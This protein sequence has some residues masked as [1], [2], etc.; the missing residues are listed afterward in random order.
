VT[1]AE[2]P[3]SP[4]TI[5][6]P[7][8]IRR[9]TILLALSQAFTGAGMGMF[10]AIGPLM[11]TGISGSTVLAGLSVTLAGLAR[12]L[13]AY[14]IGRVTDTHGRKPAMLGGLACA[15]LGTLLVGVAMLVASL[16]LLLVALLVFAMAMNAAYQLRVAATDMYPPSRR[17]EGL[18]FVLTG[19]LLGV[20]VG[21]VLI[22]IS[23]SIAPSLGV[24][25][26]G[27]PWL[28]F[29]IV[30][31]PGMYCIS[32][33][34]P[35][36]KEIAQCLGDFYPGF[37]PT[38]R[39]VQRPARSVTLRNFL[40]HYPRR[41][42]VFTNVAAQGNM[43]VVM[44]TSALLLHQ[45][46][47]TLSEISVSAAL[48][49]LGMWIVS[50]PLGRLTDRVGRRAVLMLGGVMSTG[51]AILATQTTEWWSITLGSFLVGVGWSAATVAATVVIA[52]TTAASERGRGVGLNDSLT[53]GASILIPLIAGPMAT[54]F[55]VPSTGLLAAALMVPPVV[56]LFGLEESRPGV[57]RRAVEPAE[58]TS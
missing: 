41:V 19:S 50:I 29:P 49:S 10:Y 18:G 12:F 44:V 4:R 38:V 5:P 37:Q 57:Y 52:D 33:I 36:P 6:I 3:S 32:L 22:T 11:V 25:P 9:N 31:L 43:T 26:L 1:I 13:T 46:G 30:I 14:P 8:L 56:L 21:P 23:Q 17:A 47:S 20:V 28:L 42:A 7:P 54:A 27:L 58:A 51:A 55:G 45:H 53:A 15:L 2:L 34:H 16:P 39:T 24:D 35:D 40:S 48:H